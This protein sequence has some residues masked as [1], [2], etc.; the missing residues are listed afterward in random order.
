MAN[1]IFYSWQSDS[2]NSTNR[3]FIQ[4]ALERAIDAVVDEDFTLDPALDRDT[5]NVSGAPNV[6]ATIL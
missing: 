5:Q 3:N 1:L 2:P 4:D 6:A